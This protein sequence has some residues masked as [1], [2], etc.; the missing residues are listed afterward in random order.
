MSFA[1]C[2]LHA[3]LLLQ[4]PPSTQGIPSQKTGDIH[5]NDHGTIAIGNNIRINLAPSG[6]IHQQR[7]V[8]SEALDSALKPLRDVI[9]FDSIADFDKPEDVN[10]FRTDREVIYTADQLA[11]RDSILS[12]LKR[13]AQTLVDVYQNNSTYFLDD[14]VAGAN[15]LDEFRLSPDG[16]NELFPTAT[17]TTAATATTTTTTASTVKPAGSA[18]SNGIVNLAQYLAAHKSRA[19]L[20]QT[21][22]RMDPVI[23]NLCDFFVAE[24]DVV[25]EQAHIDFNKELDLETIFIREDRQ[26]NPIE[27][28]QELRTLRQMVDTMRDTEDALSDL[29]RTLFRFALAHHALA[30]RMQT[31]RAFF[32]SGIIELLAASSSL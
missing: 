7:D 16:L 21:V 19:G 18:L 24:L 20:P 12:G 29:R 27:R 6:P 30:T 8:R 5:N 32:Q 26:L 31:D 28:R 17:T 22:L 15:L 1:L 25:T 9:A 3:A 11:V 2:G 4:A 10:S 23:Q 13:Y 14:E